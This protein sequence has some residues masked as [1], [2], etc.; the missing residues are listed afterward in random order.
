MDKRIVVLLFSLTLMVTAFVPT[1]AAIEFTAAV[2][3]A[4]DK[5]TAAANSATASKINTLYSELITL[6]TQDRSW[7]DKIKAIH[8]KNEEAI[9]LLRK[10][11]KLIDAEKLSKL[12]IQVNQTR[13]RYKP[14]FALSTSINQQIKTAKSLKNKNLN[15][16]LQA[17]A[18]S[19]KIAVQ[20]ARQD[21]KAK[22]S[23]LKS[24][25]DST[26]KTIKRLRGMLAETDP[27]HVQIKA[28][29]SKI[30]VPKKNISTEWKNFNQAIKKSNATSSLNSL[31]SLVTHSRQVNGYK[32][33]IHTLELKI[34]D[35]IIAA[36]AQ[37]PK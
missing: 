2:K 17:Q 23:A 25:K 18:T 35:I 22:E 10:Q 27:I 24:A 8:Y 1:A 29:R 32:Q 36:R 33:K 19:I 11:I 34:G 30:T 4:L 28:E 31:T 12:E 5:T 3:T 9:I 6:Q 37:L 20:L 13:E 15:T 7:D 26:A 16:F 21:I 14:L